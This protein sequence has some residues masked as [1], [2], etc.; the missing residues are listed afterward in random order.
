MDVIDIEILPNWNDSYRQDDL[1]L[2]NLVTRPK[3]KTGKELVAE[4]PTP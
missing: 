3:R 4:K 2:V 1:G